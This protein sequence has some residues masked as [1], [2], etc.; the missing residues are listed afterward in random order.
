MTSRDPL[1][2]TLQAW[3]HQPATAPQFQAEVWARIQAQEAQTASVKSF[4]RWAIPLAASLALFAG[5]G[6]ARQR[7]Q[8][9]HTERMAAAYVQSIDPLQM[10]GPVRR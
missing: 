7:A 2:D 8:Q 3:P 1:S 10:H 6:T 5:I 4:Y 9:Q